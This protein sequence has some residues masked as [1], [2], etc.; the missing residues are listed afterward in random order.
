M[1]FLCFFVAKP[2]PVSIQLRQLG[3]QVCQGALKKRT[4][5]FIARRFQRCQSPG[6]DEQDTFTFGPLF[7]FELAWFLLVWS[8]V[9]GLVLA[10]LFFYGFTFPT[11]CHARIIPPER[12]LVHGLTDECRSRWGDHDSVPAT[13]LRRIERM[14]GFFDQVF[15]QIF[16]LESGQ[17]AAE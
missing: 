11:T 2:P 8:P 17:S 1:C 14:I 4:V 10:D 3:I 6:A 7:D 13:S 5:S 12:C 16:G 15:R 9:F